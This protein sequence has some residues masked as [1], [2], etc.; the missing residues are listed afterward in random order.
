MNIGRCLKQPYQDESR[1]EQNED[2]IRPPNHQAF[3]RLHMFDPIQ[4]FIPLKGDGVCVASNE[5]LD[6]EYVQALSSKHVIRANDKFEMVII[7]IEV[8]NRLIS[9]LTLFLTGNYF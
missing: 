5:N 1:V 3:F 7:Q 6:F 2:D 8:N 9:Y 4:F